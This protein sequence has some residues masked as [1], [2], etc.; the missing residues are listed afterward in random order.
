MLHGRLLAA[1]AARAAESLGS[2]FTPV[3]LT[4]DLFRAAP[5]EPVEIEADV[6]R[7]GG[8]VR[9]VQMVLHCAGREAARASALLLRPGPHPPGQVWSPPAWTVPPPDSVPPGDAL[10]VAHLD[11]RLLTEGGLYAVTQKQLWV[12]EVHDLVEG[13]PFSPF[14][15]AVA[16]ADL[17]NPFGNFSDEGL[18]FINADLT[19]YVGRPPVGEWM[20]LEILTRTSCAGISAV[21]ANLYDLQGP[22]GHTSVASVTTAPHFDPAAP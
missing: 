19:V 17:A 13:D 11:I 12:R 9:S 18:S 10:D 20:G 1:L 16:A 2:P 7:D 22:V 5:M 6:V 15:R 3:R 21:A 14:Q 8:R 4:I